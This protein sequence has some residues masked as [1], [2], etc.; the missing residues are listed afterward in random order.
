MH[1]HASIYGPVEPRITISDRKS[2]VTSAP[3]GMFDA[4]QQ[5]FDGFL[6]QFLTRQRDRSKWGGNKNNEQPC[7]L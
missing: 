3:P 4:A 2:V 5:Q 7:S 1:R 6:P